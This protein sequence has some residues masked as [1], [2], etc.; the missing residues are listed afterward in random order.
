VENRPVPRR[1]GWDWFESGP[2]LGI[3][4]ILFVA[5]TLIMLSE[6]LNRSLRDVSFFWAE[7]A[8]RYLMLWAFFLTLGLAGRRGYHIRTELLVD[9]VP[10]RPRRA[11][12]FLSVV[13]GILFSVALFA[14]SLPQLMRYYTMGMMSESDLDIPQWVIFL[15]MP[16]G[17][18]LLF[19][20]YVRSLFVFF[21]GEDPY[22]IH[23]PTG[24][25]L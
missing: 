12:H 9:H 5:S 7:E 17:S 3:A 6:G 8:V 22:A 16:I 21:R 1:T 14:A 13:A 24:S 15:A 25:E 2:V 11:M 23:G 19:G 10:R 4:A 20:Y 18:A